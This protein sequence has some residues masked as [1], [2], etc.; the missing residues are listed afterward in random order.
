MLLFFQHYRT[1][2][3][4]VGAV[5]QKDCGQSSLFTKRV[6]KAIWSHPSM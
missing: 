3:F 5:A 2:R 1:L 6:L 4:C